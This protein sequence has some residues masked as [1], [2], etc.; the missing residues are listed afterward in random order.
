MRT[1]T[2]V[3]SIAAPI[4][5]KDVDTDMILPAEFLTRIE[6]TGFGDGL[7]VR[8]RSNNPAFYLNQSRFDGAQILVADSNFG[9]GSSREHA[10]WALRDAGVRVIIAP[11]FADI[12]SSNSAK[13][14]LLLITLEGAVVHTL[15]ERCNSEDVNLHVDLSSQQVSDTTGRCWDFVYDQFRKHCLLEGVDDLGY[16]RSRQALIEQRKAA[17]QDEWFY[18][19]GVPNR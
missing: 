13:N 17:Q 6:R 2:T 7:F 12:F 19:V 1:F 9:C 11:S 5:I 10:V 3:S 16:L 15:L 8:L 18:R 14:G 4:P